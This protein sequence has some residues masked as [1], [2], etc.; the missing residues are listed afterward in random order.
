MTVSQFGHHR[1][2]PYIWCHDSVHPPGPGDFLPLLPVPQSWGQAVGHP[3]Q[4]SLCPSTA[5][6]QVPGRP[7]GL[8]GCVSVMCSRG[9]A[10]QFLI[11]ARVLGR[12]E[13]EG[14][15][16]EGGGRGRMVF[17]GELTLVQAVSTA[18]QPNRSSHLGIHKQANTCWSIPI[19]QTVFYHFKHCRKWKL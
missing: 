6:Q 12:G 15:L 18:C 10:A 3:W 1:P 2:W 4:N 14:E 19:S 8:S 11:S 9:P 17:P 5:S 16:G 7:G 13:E